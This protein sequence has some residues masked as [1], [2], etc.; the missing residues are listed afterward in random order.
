MG[1]VSREAPS[2]LG[3]LRLIASPIVASLAPRSLRGP[4]KAQVQ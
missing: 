3:G 1:G 2:G 4:Y